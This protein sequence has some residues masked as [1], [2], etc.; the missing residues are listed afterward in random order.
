VFDEVI[1]KVLSFNFN[2]LYGVGV[3]CIFDDHH[4]TSQLTHSEYTFTFVIF[5]TFKFLYISNLT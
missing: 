1:L 2:F 5:F 3:F 4:Y